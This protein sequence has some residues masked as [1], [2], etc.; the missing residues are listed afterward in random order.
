MNELCQQNKI[1]I[2]ICQIDIVANFSAASR[3][4]WF[5]VRVPLAKITLNTN[6]EN[7][8]HDNY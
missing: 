7:Y 1:F 5:V 2:H 4:V 8:V 6:Y 3:R